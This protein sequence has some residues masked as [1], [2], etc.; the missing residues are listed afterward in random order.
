MGIIKPVPHILSKYIAQIEKQINIRMVT[1]FDIMKTRMLSSRHKF[2]ALIIWRTVLLHCPHQIVW[3]L[4]THRAECPA[5]IA[6]TLFKC[7]QAV[8]MDKDNPINISQHGKEIEV[9]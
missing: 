1:C 9:L 3:Y 6:S 7:L 2:T 5:G 8:T 4:I